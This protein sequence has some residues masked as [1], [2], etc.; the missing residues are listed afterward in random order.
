MARRPIYATPKWVR[1]QTHNED[2]V[3]VEPDRDNRAI[4]WRIAGHRAVHWCS[5]QQVP[6][7]C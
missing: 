6:S 3:G 5:V 7:R 4:Y 2:N 1:A